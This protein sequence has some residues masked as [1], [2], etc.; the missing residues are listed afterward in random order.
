MADR[1]SGLTTQKTLAASAASFIWLAISI[2]ALAA[3]SNKLLCDEESDANLDIPVATLTTKAVEHQITLNALE[4]IVVNSRDHKLAAAR[5]L[6]P[7]AEAA[8]RDAFEDSALE[9]EHPAPDLSTSVLSRPVAGVDATAKP[10][11]QAPQADALP[12][13][14]TRLP[15][16]SEDDLSRFKKQMYRRDI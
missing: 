15:G 7:R 11:G 3:S 12:G 6:A 5:L 2:P 13:M 9:E 14:N 10:E 16:V 4:D 8:I 1:Y